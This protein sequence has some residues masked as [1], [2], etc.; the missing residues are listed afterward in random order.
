MIDATEPISSQKLQPA[1]NELYQA[2]D[3]EEDTQR[4]SSH[5]EQD[6]EFFYLL[7]GGGWHTYSCSLCEE[8]IAMKQAQERKLDLLAGKMELRPGMY[9]LDVG[10]G[11]GGPLVYLCSKYGVKGHGIAVTAKQ[12]DE[13]R[14]LAARYGV[15]ATFQV[16]HWKNLPEV[17][18]YDAIYTD[19][20]MVH[21]QDL[22]GFFDKCHKALKS[23]QL[24]V[25][26][27]LHLSH[28][29]YSELGPMSRYVNQIYALTGNYIPLHRELRLLDD[30]HFQL[31]SLTEIPMEH[32]RQTLDIW[33]KS[34]FENR[35]R[36]KELEGV[37]TYERFR[38][39]LKSMRYLFTH[40][41][42]FG[43][44]VVTSRKMD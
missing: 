4:A 14:K 11:W 16:L 41:D 42:I 33:L 7:T 18:T 38:V 30:N 40:T 17:Q 27:E 44:H 8:G 3:L 24:M 2:F 35:T 26:K 13:A 15:E 31:K 39:Y 5:Y 32:Y 25:H 34:M 28:S 20:T 19:E 43:L 37:E 23:R 12:I 22:G 10:C 6:P 21:F 29:S 36:M 1:G 9:I